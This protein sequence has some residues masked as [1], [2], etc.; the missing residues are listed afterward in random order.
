MTGAIFAGIFL[1]T[2]GSIYGIVNAWLDIEYGGK[3]THK[4]GNYIFPI[5]FIIFYGA[6]I[7]NYDLKNLLTNKK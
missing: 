1:Y 3:P 2:I 7:L 4:I 5:Y 6:K